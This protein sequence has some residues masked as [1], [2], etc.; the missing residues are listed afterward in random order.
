MKIQISFPVT[1]VYHQLATFVNNAV[2]FH[3]F[4]ASHS[5]KIDV[6]SSTFNNTY[7][8]ISQLGILI[9]S[10]ATLKFNEITISN[11]FFTAIN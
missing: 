4:A 7:N 6:D 1:L 10:L 3:L 9:M 5:L 2:G 11:S 8:N